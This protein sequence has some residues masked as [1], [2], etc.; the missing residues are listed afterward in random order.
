MKAVVKKSPIQQQGFTLIELVVVIVILGILAATA[1]PK[2]IDL[3]DDA[4]DAAN[5]GIAAAM[6][7]AASLVYAKA[8]IA[9]KEA[10]ASGDTLAATGTVTVNL[11]YGYPSYDS[12]VSLL[13][14]S[15][16]FLNEPFPSD[17]GVS[18]YRSSADEPTAL[19]ET[20]TVN[21]IQSTGPGLRPTIFVTSC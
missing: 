18:V 12:I 16:D 2:F 3:Q 13:D 1:A 11:V 10:S 21:Y 8:V 5:D 7:S 6:E 14:L 15:S 9:G 19:N 17:T 20:C 4:R